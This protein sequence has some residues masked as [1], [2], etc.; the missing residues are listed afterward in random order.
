MDRRFKP[1][2]LGLMTG[3]SVA[4]HLFVGQT[5]LVLNLLPTYGT[6]ERTRGGSRVES[7]AIPQRYCRPIVQNVLD[8]TPHKKTNN[9]HAEICIRDAVTKVVST[10]ERNC[11]PG[12]LKKASYILRWHLQRIWHKLLSTHFAFTHSPFIANYTPRCTDLPMWP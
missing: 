1:E 4:C 10:S 12:Y 7:D 3:W 5:V 6:C 8:R 2:L 11:D 9:N